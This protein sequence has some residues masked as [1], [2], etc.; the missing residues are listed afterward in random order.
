MSTVHRSAQERPLKIRSEKM[1]KHIAVVATNTEGMKETGCGSI[2][3][4]RAVYDAL[5]KCYQHVTFHEV[6]STT[7]L[8]NIVKQ[9]PDLVVLTSKYFINK[10]SNAKTWLSQYFADHSI[11]FTGF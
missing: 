11:P 6:T 10:Q 2:E 3:T 1:C 4:C 9:A 7:I 8:N 5:T